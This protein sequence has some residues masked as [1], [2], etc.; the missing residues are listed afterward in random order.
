MIKKFFFI[1]IVLLLLDQVTKFLILQGFSQFQPQEVVKNTLSIFPMYNET[2]ILGF[3]EDPFGVGDGYKFIYMCFFISL[4]LGGWWVID[5]LKSLPNK[6]L[7]NNIVI[8]M[9]FISG[10][11]L[12][13]SFDRF[14][15]LGVVD[16]LHIHNT[17]VAFNFADV[18]AYIGVLMSLSIAAFVFINH[19]QYKNIKLA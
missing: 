1:S 14:A 7:L 6:E 8:A 13:N 18:F 9:A 11:G 12:G 10:A 17:A 3:L 16:F 5:K 15:R 2:T 19:K 4:M